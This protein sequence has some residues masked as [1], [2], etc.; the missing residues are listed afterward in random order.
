MSD[1]WLPVLAREVSPPP[2]GWGLV[3]GGVV[4]LAIGG[5]LVFQAWAILS[6]VPKSGRRSG[7][8]GMFGYM[9][10]LGVV[11]LAVALV[12]IDVGL[13]EKALAWLAVLCAIAAGVAGV[14]LVAQAR[15]KR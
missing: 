4:L 12:L 5:F 6:D 15:R 13:V 10:W 9:G 1:R 14:Y 11:L 7:A 3:V 8:P 2:Q